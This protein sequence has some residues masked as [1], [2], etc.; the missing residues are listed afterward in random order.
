MKACCGRNVA[1]R[2]QTRTC[3]W[4][5]RIHSVTLKRLHGSRASGPTEEPLERGG[6]PLRRSAKPKEKGTR[7]TD[8]RSRRIEHGKIPR[9]SLRKPLVDRYGGSVSISHWNGFGTRANSALS[10]EFSF[11]HD[12]VFRFAIDAQSVAHHASYSS[13]SRSLFL[14]FLPT[15]RRGSREIN[16]RRVSQGWYPRWGEVG[17]RGRG[18]GRILQA[19]ARSS[20]VRLWRR[21][22]WTD[23]LHVTAALCSSGDA[24]RRDAP[25]RAAPR[26]VGPRR[27]AGHQPASR[28]RPVGVLRDA[29]GRCGGEMQ[30][31]IGVPCVREHRALV[32]R[33][34]RELRRR[35]GGAP[36]S[37]SPLDV[38]RESSS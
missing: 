18:R 38:T 17:D 19:D 11:L 4:R 9:R 5:W 7:C 2:G 29:A 1:R 14:F 8:F 30:G 36:A 27:R 10:R 15:V 26:R 37:R 20:G 25:R 33:Q 16:R 35:S 28:V 6:T 21:Q 24:R 31:Y 32:S 34:V 23:F 12:S 3:T 22:R 13:L